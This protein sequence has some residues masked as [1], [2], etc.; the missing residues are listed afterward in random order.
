MA[1]FAFYQFEELGLGGGEGGKGRG[2]VK[3]VFFRFFFRVYTLVL[4]GANATGKL[5]EYHVGF[6][7]IV[8]LCYVLRHLEHSDFLE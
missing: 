2:E 1:F 6:Y 7:D 3:G 4:G 8:V 5:Y